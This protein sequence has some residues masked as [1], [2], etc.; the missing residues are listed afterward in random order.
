MRSHLFHREFRI[1]GSAVCNIA[2]ASRRKTAFYKKEEKNS[3]PCMSFPAGVFPAGA[4]FCYAGGPFLCLFKRLDKKPKWPS[5]LSALVNVDLARKMWTGATQ[6]QVNPL[7]GNQ[8]CSRL[9]FLSIFAV[10][11]LYVGYYSD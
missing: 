9:A 6:E 5:S 4:S 10:L 1:T 8:V 2:T 3:Q 11:G 7:H